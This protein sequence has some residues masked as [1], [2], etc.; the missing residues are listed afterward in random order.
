[1]KNDRLPAS[2]H[3]SYYEMSW[4]LQFLKFFKNF[5]KASILY[6]TFCQAYWNS[7]MN[8]P[9]TNLQHKKIKNEMIILVESFFI[10]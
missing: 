2:G 5:F 6:I 8:L 4:R 1:M 10:H 3:T 9:S 7:K